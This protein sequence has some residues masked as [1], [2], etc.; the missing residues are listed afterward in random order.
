MKWKDAAIPVPLP[1]QALDHATGYL[2]AT[3]VLQGIRQRLQNGTGYSAR[4]SLARTAELLLRHPYP[5]QHRL[6][7][8]ASVAA[9]DENPETE[10]TCWGPAQ[11]L[12]PALWLNGTALLWALPATPLG[13]SQPAWLR[14]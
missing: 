8:L 11:R 5:P 3:A 12:N 6:E 13:R 9:T 1:V 7:P 10:L 4:L 14:R 2:M